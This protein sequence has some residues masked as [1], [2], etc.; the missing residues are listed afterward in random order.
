MHTM[1][2]GTKASSVGEC[3][4]RIHVVLAVESYLVSLVKV[5]LAQQ[6]YNFDCWQH[7]GGQ[8]TIWFTSTMASLKLYVAVPARNR[9]IF[10]YTI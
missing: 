4:K 6:K 10:C 5:V 3:E 7:H 9:T 1:I 8:G 2:M